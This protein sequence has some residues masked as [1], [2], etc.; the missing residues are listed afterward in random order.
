MTR[1]ERCKLAIERGYTYDTET[2]LIYNTTNE[3]VKG[4]INGYVMFVLIY[5]NKRFNLYGHHFAWYWVNIECIEEIDHINGVRDDNRIINLRSVSRSE[6][7]W[8]RTTAKG[9]SWNK[10]ENK[11]QSQIKI[12]KKVIHLGYYNI[13]QEARNA[14][15]AAKEIYH[16][17]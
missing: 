9:Y 10:R 4:R 3:P 1:E 13:E 7:Q 5:N 2:G 17:I 6:N 12:N 16:K 15:L 8:N 11:W 14:Y